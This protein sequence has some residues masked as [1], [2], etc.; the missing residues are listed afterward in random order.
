MSAVRLSFRTFARRSFSR[1]L[2]VFVVIL[3]AATFHAQIVETGIITGI[4]KD[5]TG[6]AI[7]NAHVDVLNA[8]TGLKSNTN[9][10]SQG[11]FVSPPLHPGDYTVVVEAPG[12]SKVVEHVRLEVG[13]RV[14]ADTVAARVEVPLQGVRKELVLLYA[15][16][17]HIAF[18]GHLSVA[19]G[20]EQ[21]D[22]ERIGAF[23]DRASCGSQLTSLSD[24][25]KPQSR[26]RIV[27]F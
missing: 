9:S 10:D 21:V 27:G 23:G 11:I 24:G 7:P 18:G 12:F 22:A 1:L 17:E 2:V 25:L 3:A 6:A 15:V 13:Q 20:C 26:C 14:N 4:V 16:L 8:N 5:N 19:V